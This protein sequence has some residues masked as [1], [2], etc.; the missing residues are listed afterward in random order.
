M[1][2]ALEL[3]A[4][5][6]GRVEPNPMV[7]CLIASADRVLG[8]GFHEQFG[9]AHAEVNAIGQ[10]VAHGSQLAGSTAYVTLEPCCHTGK[11]PPCTRALIEA[12]VAEVVVACRDP[13]PQ[14]D[15]GGIQELA[16]AGIRVRSGLLEHE[17]IELNR[18]YLQ[19]LGQ[20]RPWVIAK[21][22]MT[23]DGKMA[24]P[25]GDSQWISS[26]ASR[27]R[28]HALRGRMDGILIGAQTALVDDPLLTARPAGPRVAT[29]IVVDSTARLSPNSQL[30]KTARET[31]LMVVTGPKADTEQCRRLEAAGCELFALSD[32]D[33]HGRLI[34]LLNEL[35]RRRFTNLLVEGGADLLGSLFDLGL[36]NEAHVFIAPIVAGGAAATIAVGGEGVAQIAA[37]WRLGDVS[38]E[39]IG[40]DVY[41]RGR[42]MPAKPS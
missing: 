26:A 10:A 42:V 2:R 31:P 13:F 6:Q 25:S 9:A 7:G 3:A 5:G 8:E 32:H 29:R 36:V 33:P 17:A 18:P 1:R 11:T 40:T 12:G 21:W 19:L 35:G 34:A 28:G 41:V 39:P 14:V 20:Q 37:A 30:V 4:R 15:G 23:L 16:A 38:I 24:T 22:A 27:Q